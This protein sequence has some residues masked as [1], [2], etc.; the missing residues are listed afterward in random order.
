MMLRE[1]VDTTAFVDPA[2]S[3][4]PL[5]KQRA[6]AAIVVV[7]QAEHAGRIHVFT[8]YSWARQCHTDEL[9]DKIFDVNAQFA[10][11]LF[12]AEA[13]AMQI[14]YGE[15][16]Q[17]EARQRGV[18]LKLVPVYQPPMQKKEWRI[19]AALQTLIA[20]G[21]LF[22]RPKDEEL[23]QQLLRFPQ[24]LRVDLVDALASAVTLLPVRP[25]PAQRAD[26]RAGLAQ[27]LRASGVPPAEIT[28][29]LQMAERERRSA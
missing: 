20:E 23:K 5:K 27:Y 16:L 24:A 13:N 19:R 12:G 11:P 2:A 10:S 15:S 7:A 14:L 22:L 1:L 4:S 18:K 8:R 6:Q 25:L 29:R 17:R 26:A 28:R 21:R 3:K 9:S